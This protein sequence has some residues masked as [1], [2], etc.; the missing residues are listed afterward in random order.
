M[1]VPS[2]LSE[3]AKDDFRFGG[4]GFGPGVFREMGIGD[5][6]EAGI[7]W[8]VGNLAATTCRAR[9]TRDNEGV[10]ETDAV[11]KNGNVRRSNK[12]NEKLT[13]PFIF[14]K[15]VQAFFE[16]GLKGLIEVI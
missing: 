6:L 1:A 8:M 14:L 11:E 4:L 3:D 16:R 9:T 10:R 2:H 7:A 5:I 15:D 13:A 12:A